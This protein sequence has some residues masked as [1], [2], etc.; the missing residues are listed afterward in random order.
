MEKTKTQKKINAKQGDFIYYEGKFWMIEKFDPQLYGGGYFAIP[1]YFT[2]DNRAEVRHS[3]GNWCYA[4]NGAF[5]KY[6]EKQVAIQAYESC[7]K[8]LN[9]SKKM[10]MESTNYFD[11][12]NSKIN[13]QIRLFGKLLK[14]AQ[15]I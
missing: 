5:L 11:E 15:G 7:L 3:G 14:V 1:V 4:V 10:Q 6:P 8:Y 12:V 2:K 9:W 13:K